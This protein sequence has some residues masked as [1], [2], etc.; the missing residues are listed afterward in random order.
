VE[1]RSAPNDAVQVTYFAR[2]DLVFPGKVTAQIRAIIN[3][4]PDRL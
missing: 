2:S 4:C 1:F 3:A